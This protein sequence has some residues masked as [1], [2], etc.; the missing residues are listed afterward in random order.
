LS[1][2]RPELAIVHFFIGTAHDRL[3]EYEDALAA[4]ETFLAAAD[5]SVNRLEIDKVSLRLPSL[6]NQ[7]KRGEG[8]KLDKKTQ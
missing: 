2:A 5:P 8:L 3:G 6:R 4:Y 1:Q 7:I